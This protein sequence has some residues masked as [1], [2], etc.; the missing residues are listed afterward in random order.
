MFLRKSLQ[1]PGYRCEILHSYRGVWHCVS[2]K[3][4]F[5]CLLMHR[6]NCIAS[7]LKIFSRTGTTESMGDF[8]LL[9]LRKTPGV[10]AN[11]ALIF[12]SW[13]M[14]YVASLK[15]SLIQERHGPCPNTVISILFWKFQLFRNW[16]H[17]SSKCIFPAGHITTPDFIRMA[18]IFRRSLL[19]PQA[20]Q[21]WI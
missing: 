12:V 4:I 1:S 9:N 13:N 3:G 2:V 19:L 15:I 6:H 17:E 21:C 10:R 18:K 5:T 16:T 8:F 11:A 7:S 14:H 20:W